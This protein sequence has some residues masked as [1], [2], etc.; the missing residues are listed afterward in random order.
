MSL[1]WRF[2]TN[3]DEKGTA[4]PRRL[5]KCWLDSFGREDAGDEA[6]LLVH[7]MVS[8]VAPDDG[9]HEIAG[10]DRGDVSGGMPSNRES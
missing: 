10:S 1:R 7:S 3:P 9:E 2:P 8:M 4:N 5:K 6:R